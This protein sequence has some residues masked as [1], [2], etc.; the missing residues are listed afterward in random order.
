MNLLYKIV[1]NIL[2]CNFLFVFCKNAKKKN[3]EKYLSQNV[4]NTK[5]SIFL[6]NKFKLIIFLIL[7]LYLPAN[8]LTSKTAQSKLL[9]WQ[10]ELGGF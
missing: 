3:F 1:V 2:I 9:K 6:T 7:I 5:N 4:Q 8:R 10:F